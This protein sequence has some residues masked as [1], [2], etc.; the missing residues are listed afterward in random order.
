MKRLRDDLKLNTYRHQTRFLLRLRRLEQVSYFL[1]AVPASSC[2]V[3]K[4]SCVRRPES[5]LAFDI[6]TVGIELTKKW[7]VVR[8]S[9]VTNRFDLLVQSGKIRVQMRREL[10]LFPRIKAGVRPY[11]RDLYRRLVLR[12]FTITCRTVYEKRVGRC[13]NSGCITTK[14]SHD[15]VDNLV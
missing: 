12:A 11:K 3:R 5:R 4:R 1:D 8:Y 10:K 7:L 13:D 15:A 6:S 2:R 14:G 9:L